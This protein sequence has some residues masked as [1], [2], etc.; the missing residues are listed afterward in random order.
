M[1]LNSMI[2]VAGVIFGTVIGIVY[3]IRSRSIAPPFKVPPKPL[4]IPWEEGSSCGG[5]GSWATRQPTTAKEG[6]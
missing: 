4:S 6:E 3:G 5:C 1:D 2:V